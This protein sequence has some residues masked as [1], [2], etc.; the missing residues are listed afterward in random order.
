MPQTP[1]IA[2]RYN[3]I[4]P[5]GSG[6]STLARKLSERLDLSYI[7]LDQVYWGPNWSEPSDAEFF[8]NLQS[9]LQSAGKNW[10]I[11][12]NYTRTIPIKWQHVQTV[13]W[14]DYPLSLI[15][16]RAFSRAIRR[17]LSRK[18]LW[19]NTG[20]RETFRKTFLSQNSILLWT[21]QS[22]RP[23]RHRYQKITTNPHYRHI[24][25]LRFTQQSDTD[26]FLATLGL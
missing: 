24:R 20:N 26:N 22:Y 18:E 21:L 11:D 17:I 12:G 4:G 7:Q 8:S 19:P 1:N 3:V 23:L 6:K 2:T 9:A 16:P 14:L 10:V 13:I 25:F 15:F 5:S